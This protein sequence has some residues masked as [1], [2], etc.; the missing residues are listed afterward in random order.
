[1]VVV[2]FL[3]AYHQCKRISCHENLQDISDIDHINTSSKLYML[4]QLLIQFQLKQD[5]TIIFSHSTQI[6]IFLY[7]FLQHK[8]LNQ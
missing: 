6:L 5:K 8:V 7:K 1:M 2:I 4:Y 3:E